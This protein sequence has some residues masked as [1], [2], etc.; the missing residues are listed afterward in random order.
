[1]DASS[2]GPLG[3][4]VHWRGLCRFDLARSQRAYRLNRCLAALAHHET[5]AEYQ[6]DPHA[7]RQRFGLSEQECALLTGGDFAAML[8]YGA[9]L[10]L[11]G[12]AAAA[13]GT[14]LMEMGLAQR[15]CTLQQFLA[16]K[17]SHSKDTPWQL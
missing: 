9:N 6:S 8:D 12:N 2:P 3:P 11:L 5:R 15:G 16:W 10:I 13:F 14:T 7:V 17:Q 1:M 4:P